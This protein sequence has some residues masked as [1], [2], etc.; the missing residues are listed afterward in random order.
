MLQNNDYENFLIGHKMLI[1][2]SFLVKLFNLASVTKPHF[3]KVA[4]PT[5]LLYANAFCA[6]RIK[7]SEMCV[8]TCKFILILTHLYVR[9]TCTE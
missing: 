2:Q 1:N 4:F 3:L 9:L 5:S 7:I 8:C 6:T